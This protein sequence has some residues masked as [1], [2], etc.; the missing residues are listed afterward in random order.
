MECFDS[1]GVNEIKKKN[2]SHFCKFKNISKI[3]F[4]ETQLQ[5]DSSL[6]CG[7]FVLYFAIQRMH[8]LDLSFNDFLN[9]AFTLNCE[10]NE[11]IVNEFVEQFFSN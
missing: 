8:N 4:N 6:S 5:S 2:L 10:K 7:K 11:D 3:K 1:L 9:E